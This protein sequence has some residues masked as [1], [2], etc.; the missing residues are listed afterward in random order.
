MRRF[1]LTLLLAILTASPCPAQESARIDLEHARAELENKHVRVVRLAVPAHEIVLLK[2]LR[3]ESVVVSVRQA[4]LKV[5]PEKGTPERWEAAPGSAMWMRGGVGHSL[6]N[7]SDAAVE[8][9]VVELR[10]S[11]AFGRVSVPHS[12]L[13]PVALD[14]RHF[15]V[16]LENEHLRVLLLHAGPHEVTQD[17][18]FSAGV[19]ISLYDAHTN[20]AWAD[21][22]HGEDRRIAG[23]VSWEKDGLY[24]IQNL[25][26]KPLDSVLLELK[27]PFCYETP[28][29]MAGISPG[30]EP[31][32][33]NAIKAVREKWYK[34]MPREARHAEKGR[35]IIQW[36]IQRDGTV[37]E[38][39]IVMT[40]VFASDS[41]VEA[42]LSAIRKVAPFPPL[43]P[44]FHEQFAEVRFIF[45]YNLPLHQPGCN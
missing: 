39:D 44:T 17:A 41:L 9:L 28:D 11:Y 38:E 37:R 13:D 6:E 40:S 3:V 15:R 32:M 1:L 2:E 25:D 10:D 21:G 20:K 34:A 33:E 27:H 8:I 4:S 30:M 12:V 18:Q 5:I 19:L 24:S 26:E 7:D 16:A 45:L 31:Y 23:A 29:P 36:K 22:T 43:P 42:A 35:V 14:P